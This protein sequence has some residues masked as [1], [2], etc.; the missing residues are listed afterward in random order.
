M[1]KTLVSAALTMLASLSVMSTSYAA[2]I[3][4]NSVRVRNAPSWLRASRVNKVVDQIQSKLEWDIRKIDS[5]FYSSASEFQKVHGFSGIVLA[6]ARRSDNTI[7]IGPKVNTENFDGV[8]GHELVHVILN[9]KYKDAIPK[10]LEEG[11]AN[12][13]AKKGI[14]D[15]N[16]LNRK[17]LPDVRSLGHPFQKSASDKSALDHYQVSRAAIEMIASKCSLPELLQL[18]VGKN[19]E[20]YLNTFCGIPDINQAFKAWV[21][22]KK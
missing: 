19:L 15:Y 7:H 21:K 1:P 5:Y 12:Y 3:D 8:F 20:S 18:S 6:V 2:N 14:V 10:W 13:V 17:A 22:R 11:L 4:T 9:Q 16:G